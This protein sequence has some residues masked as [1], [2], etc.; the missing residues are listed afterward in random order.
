MAQ[1]AYLILENGKI[2]EG[3]Y[4]G[5]PKEITGE[6]VFTTNMGGH[7]ETLTDKNYFGQIVVQTFP[8]IGN[9]GI[10]QK[11]FESDKVYMPA[12]VVRHLC[13]YPSNFQSEGKLEDYFIREGLTGIYGID[14]RALTKIIRTSGEMNAIICSDPKYADLKKLKEY[15]I[16]DSVKQVSTKTEHIEKAKKTKFTVAVIDLGINNKIKNELLRRGLELHIFPAD[17][18]VKKIMEVKPRGVFLTNGPGNPAENIQV[19]RTVK[20]LLNYQIPI[21]G[22]G[23]GHQIIAIA[24][25]FKTEKLKHGHRGSNQ[26][27]KNVLTNWIYITNQNHSYAVLKK[28]IDKRIANEYFVNI[29]DT[30]NEGLEYKYYPIFSLQFDPETDSSPN[31]TG[32][33]YDRFVSNMEGSNAVR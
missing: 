12:Y 30:T 27:V 17:T 26:A 28:S 18:D 21:M 15:R 13:D 8:L 2:F 4:F 25:G 29:N 31:D 9:Y 5:V 19:I 10:I 7:L 22:V 23:L 6:V 16:S 33:L 32:F 24:F 20:E 1:K 14:T 3:R 11:Q